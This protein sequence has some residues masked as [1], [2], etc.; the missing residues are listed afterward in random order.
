MA[1]NDRSTSF[2]MHIS[3]II[4]FSLAFAVLLV[5]GYY[6]YLLATQQF[7]PVQLPVIVLTA[8]GVITASAFLFVLGNISNDLNYM[9]FLTSVYGNDQIKYHRSMISHLKMIEDMLDKQNR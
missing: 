7:P 2:R 3:T 5:G 9:N 8:L 4:V 1:G 6:V